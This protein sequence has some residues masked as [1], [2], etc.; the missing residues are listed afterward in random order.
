MTGYYGGIGGS[1]WSG[2]TESAGEPDLDYQ[3]HT[4]SP[5]S[6]IPDPWAWIDHVYRSITTE[7]YSGA[8]GRETLVVDEYVGEGS[9]GGSIVTVQ[10][11]RELNSQAVEPLLYVELTEGPV[12]EWDAICPIVYGTNLGYH[13]A[14]LI[15]NFDLDSAKEVLV[16]G[17]NTH[18]PDNCTDISYFDWD[19]RQLVSRTPDLGFA[20]LRIVAAFLAPGLLLVADRHWTK[21]WTFALWGC[22]TLAYGGLY[23][24]G[25]IEG[26]WFALG[27]G[28]FFVQGLLRSNIIM[29][30]GAASR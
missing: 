16:N 25:L 23:I 26:C 1:G 20:W 24:G 14:V 10:M 3:K 4:A 21:G 22:I 29:G 18:S 15:A 7:S 9:D 8:V 19:N 17:A 13:P 11:F 5:T 2:I 27:L 6:K 12:Y 28:V 30:R